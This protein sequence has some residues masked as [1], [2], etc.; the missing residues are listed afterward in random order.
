MR[1]RYILEEKTTITGEGKAAEPES[2]VNYFQKVELSG[3]KVALLVN[4]WYVD[5]TK[6]IKTV[7]V[8]QKK[9]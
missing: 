1:D 9:S 3:K 7:D 2:F 4:L 5:T 6:F 8:K